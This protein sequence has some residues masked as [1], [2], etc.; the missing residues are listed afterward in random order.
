[1]AEQ[2]ENQENQEAA[3]ESSESSPAASD[4]EAAAPETPAASTETPA[5]AP[6]KPAAAAHGEPETSADPLEALTTSGR[7]L[8]EVSLDVLKDLSPEAGALNDIPQASVSKEH[9]LE[10]CRLMKADPRISAK[11]LLCLACVDYT[12]YFQ[13]V[14]IL[15]SL[16]PERTVVLRTDVPYSDASISSVSSVWRAA[17]WYER[18]AHDLFGVDFDGHPDM[19]PLLLYDGFEGFPGRRD[20]PFNEYQEF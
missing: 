7:E 12:E 19:S 5:A 17:D 3:S 18:E 9:I 10:A 13:L 8:L 14:Y 11:M 15:Q 16:E 20:F 2:E 6:A 1:M 4:T